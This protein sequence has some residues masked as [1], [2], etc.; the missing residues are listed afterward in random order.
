[1]TVWNGMKSGRMV[2]RLLLESGLMAKDSDMMM[3]WKMEKKK[4]KDCFKGYF[5]RKEYPPYQFGK[6]SQMEWE[7]KNQTSPQNYCSF[8][9]LRCKHLLSAIWIQCILF[10]AE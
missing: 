1:M 4:K 10:K 5:P 3:T 2:R 8:V 6:R 9:H 7:K